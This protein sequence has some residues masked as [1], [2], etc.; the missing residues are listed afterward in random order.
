MKAPSLPL[1]IETGET[2]RKKNTCSAQLDPFS[3]SV[4]PRS[5]SREKEDVSQGRRLNPRLRN[6]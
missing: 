6:D 2:P 4:G 5:Y 3:D 1:E